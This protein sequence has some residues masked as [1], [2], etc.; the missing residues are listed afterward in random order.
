[1][2]SSTTLR[3]AL[4][5]MAASAPALAQISPATPTQRPPAAAAESSTRADTPPPVP[6]TT[7]G[8]NTPRETAEG[9]GSDQPPMRNDAVTGATTPLPGDVGSLP[10]EPV[11]RAGVLEPGANSFTIEQARSRIEAAGFASPELLAKDDQGIWR[12]RA[13]R[14]GKPVMV[15]LDYKGNVAALR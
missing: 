2:I 4:L 9:E 5:G 11:A 15:G 13:M 14:D 8:A 1:M 12:A 6:D 10:L 3:L 7:S